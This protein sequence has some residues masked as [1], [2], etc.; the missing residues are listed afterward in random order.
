MWLRAEIKIK[1]IIGSVFCPHIFQNCLPFELENY[2][3]KRIVY[4]ISLR[5]ELA[6]PEVARNAKVRLWTKMPPS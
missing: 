1:I 4:P 5:N 6:K 2:V 3:G